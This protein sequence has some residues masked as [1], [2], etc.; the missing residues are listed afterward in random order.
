MPNRT[1]K[2]QGWGT[3]TAALT[4]SLD[5]EQIFSGDVDLVAFTDENSSAKNAPTLFTFELP[6]EFAGTKQMKIVVDKATVRF[7]MIVANYT[8]VDWGVIHYTG[9]HEFADVAS[10]QELGIKDSRANT[11]I[12]GII[13]NIER[14]GAMGTWHWTIDPGCIFEH[15][16]LIA[17]GIE[18]EF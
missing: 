18:I 9:P 2:V 4:A 8:E 12:N 5:G 16:L 10:V 13:Q 3:G 11:R 6:I 1:V 14:G 15:D 17:Q 7:G